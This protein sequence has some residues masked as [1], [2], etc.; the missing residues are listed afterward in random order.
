MPYTKYH[1]C[2]KTPFDIQYISTSHVI[3]DISHMTYA[4]YNTHHMWY[5]TYCIWYMLYIT[6]N[7]GCNIPHIQH[8]IDIHAYIV[9]I[10]AYNH[11][12]QNIIYM[13][14]IT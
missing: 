2:N 8:D 7:M 11:I 10:I 12:Q 1:I 13:Y 5:V 14:N 4:L 9:Y 3:Y 6:Y